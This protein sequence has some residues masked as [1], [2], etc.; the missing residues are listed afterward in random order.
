MT[1]L[2]LNFQPN[3]DSDEIDDTFK[4]DLNFIDFLHPEIVKLLG[5]AKLNNKFFSDKAYLNQNKI[6]FTCLS[7]VKKMGCI[8]L[9]KKAS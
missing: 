7:K 1:A 2:K 3:K 9:D 6:S 4:D 5:N 8:L